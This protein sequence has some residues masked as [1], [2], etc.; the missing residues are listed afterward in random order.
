MVQLA[1]KYKFLVKV[2]NSSVENRVEIDARKT[3]SFCNAK[4]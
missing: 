3:K 4:V 1:R 2:F